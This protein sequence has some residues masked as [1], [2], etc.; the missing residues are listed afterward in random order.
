[1][2]RPTRLAIVVAV[3]GLAVALLPAAIDAKLWALW[4]VYLGALVLALGLDALMVP[5]KSGVTAALAMPGTLYIG[6]DEEAVLTVAVPSVRRVPVT[7]AVD[8]SDRLLPQP[9]LRGRASREGTALRFRLPP[10]PPGPT[11]GGT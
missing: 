5:K 9:Q 4:P 10:T 2:M 8:L 11:G 3:L 7:V 1:M 6:E